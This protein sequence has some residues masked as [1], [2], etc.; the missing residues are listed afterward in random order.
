MFLRSATTAL[1]DRTVG[2][3]HR[4]DAKCDPG[5]NL[6][7]V[8][9]ETYLLDHD[10]RV[11]HEWSSSR[12]VQHHYD[13]GWFLSSLPD[14]NETLCMLNRQRELTLSHPTVAPTATSRTFV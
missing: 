4:E 5:Y 8:G 7:S 13:L 3:V 10:G 6:L 9:R 2:V 11:C 14:S 1:E 12:P